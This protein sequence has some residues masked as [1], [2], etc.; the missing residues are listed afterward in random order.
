MGTYTGDNSGTMF[1]LELKDDQVAM[2]T[3]SMSMGDHPK[4][5]DSWEGKWELDNDTITLHMTK[6]NGQ[7]VAED[8]P[9]KKFKLTVSEHGDKLS[10]GDMPDL[11]RK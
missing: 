7:P 5:E 11:M 2:L 3:S 8:E 9:K 4:M 6:K 10:G 1:K